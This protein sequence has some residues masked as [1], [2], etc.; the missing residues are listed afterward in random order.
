ME[1]TEWI[2]RGF[3]L[4]PGSPDG[5]WWRVMEEHVEKEAPKRA[6]MQR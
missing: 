2:P 1:K 5:R 4:G 3:F 6:A